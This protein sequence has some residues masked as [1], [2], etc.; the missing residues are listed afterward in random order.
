MD[1]V[2]ERCAGLD[3]HK[4]TVVACVRVP[5]PDGGRQQLVK[6]F[7]TTTTELLVL[8]D[9]LAAHEEEAA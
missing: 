8:R 7:S 2:I 3:I 4:D 9:W 6:T 5:E 1:A